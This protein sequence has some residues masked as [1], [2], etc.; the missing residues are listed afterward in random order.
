[1]VATLTQEKRSR[2]EKKAEI[3][4]AL[5]QL[6]TLFKFSTDTMLLLVVVVMAVLMLS[7]LFSIVDR[8]DRKLGEIF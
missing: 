6:A 8:R 4:V 3:T 2:E 1:M 5:T 7:L